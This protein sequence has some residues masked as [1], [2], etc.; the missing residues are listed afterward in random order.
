MQ[1][2]NINPQSLLI[3]VIIWIS[4]IIVF[5]VVWT[6]YDPPAVEEYRHLNQQD[7]TIVSIDRECKSEAIFWE[8]AQ[9]S[10]QALLLLICAIFAF[11][12]RK[13]SIVNDSRVLAQLVYSH[14]MFM[15]LRLM[16]TAFDLFDV[17]GGSIVSTLAS[18]NHS[19][20]T[21]FAMCIYVSCSKVYQ[22]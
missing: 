12:S 4:L 3:R 10:L 8:V 6:V 15:I 5:L 17:F 14:F 9:A 11:Q 20:D 2:I 7:S 21:L 1:R 16:V 22:V 13:V 18:F 19:F